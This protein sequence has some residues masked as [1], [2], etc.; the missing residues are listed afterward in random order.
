MKPITKGITGGVVKEL[1]VPNPEMV[2]TLAMYPEVITTMAFE[3]TVPYLIMDDQD[4]VML[5]LIKR[6]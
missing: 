3:H 5:T 1:I 2:M 4:D 6:N